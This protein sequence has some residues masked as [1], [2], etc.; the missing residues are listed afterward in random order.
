MSEVRAEVARA[1][2]P[3]EPSSVGAARRLLR[4]TTDPVARDADVDTAELLVSELVTNAV[5]HAGTPVDVVVSVLDDATVEV[6]ISDGSAELPTNRR[7]PELS[8]TGRGLHLVDA[9][10]DC[11]GVRSTVTGK[12][13]WFRLRSPMAGR[14][15]LPEGV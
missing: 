10:A 1:R 6:E 8:S 4:S 12:T 14:S 3:G 15:A 13:V 2:L 11:W 9:L 5:V 7:H